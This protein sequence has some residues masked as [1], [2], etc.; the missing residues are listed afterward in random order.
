MISLNLV[1][2]LYSGSEP[3]FPANPGT[4]SE[5]SEEPQLPNC[6]NA[7]EVPRAVLELAGEELLVAFRNLQQLCTALNAETT[8]GRRFSAA[9]FQIQV[10]LTQSRLLRLQGRLDGDFAECLRL[11]LLAF[12]ASTFQISTADAHYP[13]LAGRYRESC[14]SLEKHTQISQGLTTWFLMIGAISAFD[15]EEE[16]LLDRWRA[17][18]PSTTT[19][20][21]MRE[22]LKGI[23]WIDAVHDV[24]GQE[25]FRVLTC[26]DVGSADPG[27][28]RGYSSKVKLWATGWAG[29]TYEVS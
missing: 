1:H 5:T 16:W 26:K 10:S 24:V 11:S 14:T 12:L 17:E 21:E 18:V 19:W 22:V 27:A 28:S 4:I 23:M 13:Y 25:L 7:P 15:L 8:G 20:N 9:A 6:D 29:N 3:T 2:S